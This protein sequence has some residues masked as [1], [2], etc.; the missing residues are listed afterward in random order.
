MAVPCILTPQWSL[1]LLAKTS[2][3]T[4]EQQKGQREE[5]G[6]NRAKPGPKEQERHPARTTFA[7]HG[8]YI[9]M[10]ACGRRES[11]PLRGGHSGSYKWL[12]NTRS[13]CEASELVEVV[14]ERGH[15]DLEVLALPHV[16]DEL[17]HLALLRGVAQH[18]VPVVEDALR[19]GLAARLLA[20][21]G[22]EAEGL[23]HG[24]VGLDLQEGRALARVL[25]EDAAAPQVHAGV[26]A[27]HR[28]LRAG[29]LHEEDGLLQR[30]LPQELRGEA[31]AARRGHDLP[32]AAVD[33]VGVEGHV[34][35]VEA[36]A[37]HVLL[38]QGALLGRPLER[39]VHVLLDLVDVL[40]SLRDVHHDVRAL[41]LGAPAPDLPRRVV[42][43]PVG[44]AQ[45]ARALLRL[46]LRAQ[47]A[48]LDRHVQ[49]LRHRLRHEVDAVVLV[50][51]LGE[52]GLRGG[53]RDRLAVRD[54]GVRDG[55]V[56]LRVLLPQVLEADLHVQLAAAGDDV[57]A[58]LLGGAD[59]QRVGLRELLQALHELR[60]VLAVLG[61]HGD[62]H[63]GGD[64]VLH[65]RDVVGVL[66][67]GDGA[68]LQEEL[69]D[70][71]ERHGVA[72]RHV[73]D[74][75]RGPAHHQHRALDVLHVQVLLRARLVVRALDPHPLAGRDRATEDTAEGVEAA[76]VARRHHLGDVHHQRPSGVAGFDGAGRRVVHGALVQVLHAVLL[77]RPGRGQLRHDHR[78]QR[79][80]RVDPDLHRALHQRLA[81]EALVVA[82]EDDAE[83]AHHLLVLG[84]VVVHDGAH[85]LGD[86]AHDELAEGALQG[87]RAALGLL[88]VGPHL[89][90]GVEEVVAP[91][92]L[93]HL[94]LVHA[95]LH[96]VDLGEALDVEAPAVEAA[97]E[98]HGALLRAHLVV[99]H[100]L[101]VVRRDDD[102]DVLDGLPEAPEHV[103]GLHLQLEDAAVHLVHEEAR[104]HALR[105]RLPQHRL[106]LHGAAFDAVDDH[107]RAV[108]DPQGRRHLRGE[109]HVPRRVDEVD[110]VRLRALAVVLVEL[111]VQ[112][113]AGALDRHAALLLVRARVREARV[114]RLLRGDDA[115]LADEGVR[116]GRL[117]VVHVR[118][119]AHGADLVRLIH[120]GAD[121]LHG[122]V[123]HGCSD[124]SVERGQ[125][126]HASEG[127]QNSCN[128]EP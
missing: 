127:I 88:H 109:V 128:P 57:L 44:L 74:L 38:A 120:D 116:E 82:L 24:Q 115:R 96:R 83:R 29:D 5:M 41:D 60:Q 101:V 71:H 12:A 62:L 87:L 91:E 45:R 55:E 17:L 49:L 126:F 47:L 30:R 111:E 9:V 69:V 99:A 107:H 85:E 40:D 68:R 81:R 46:G 123:R 51:R 103:L 97:A 94:L 48:V 50:G 90:L 16:Q 72:A 1:H 37:P 25:L 63:H 70:A 86:G 43:P 98:G 117:A 113:H 36:D 31:G 119:D 76:L 59:H 4:R 6:Q 93:H 102:V 8:A 10:A 33:G 110:Q 35:D 108:G 77:R 23:G 61:L 104:L 54:H 73:R 22:D 11:V 121:L 95:H 14:A 3:Q 106:R 80:G 28:L 64:A 19:E 2:G 89:L 7:E 66:Q 52:A 34:H 20:Q 105:Q 18:V 39:A 32:R 78:E 56:A 15:G 124:L 26:D 114:A 79:V 112:G 75:L 42:V 118:D 53:L 92:A 27:A 100:Q 58:A 13:F 125:K 65:V 122:E 21:R 67:R 84:L